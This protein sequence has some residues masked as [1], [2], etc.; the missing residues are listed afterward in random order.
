[1]LSN[2]LVA[3]DCPE[4][5]ERMIECVHNLASV[6]SRHVTL[7]HVFNV[8]DVGGIYSSAKE[9]ILPKLEK[10]A[11]ML[12]DAGFE[13][14]VQTPHGIPF[15]EINRVARERSA[16]LIVMGSFGASLVENV[17]RGSTANLV[18]QNAQ[19]P[20]LLVRLQ[21]M[22]KDGGLRYQAARQDFF[23]HIPL[24]HRFFRQR[25]ACLPLPGA[26]CAANQGVCYSASRAGTIKDRES[27]EARAG[28]GQPD[29]YGTAERNKAAARTVRCR[30]RYYSNCPWL[31]CQDGS[32]LRA[33]QRLSID[34][35]GK[36]RAKFH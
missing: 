21:V 3:S 29:R 20:T 1:V 16:A 33:Q 5:S 36:P 4:A 35:H 27:P 30:L 32:G 19:L 22:Q 17:L 7:I 6:G 23:Q 34:C 10:E 14:E 9:F 8:R 28:P 31:S 25:G 18:L 12:R 26:H 15:C 2:I 13:V 11:A 24:S